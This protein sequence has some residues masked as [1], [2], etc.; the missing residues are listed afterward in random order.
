MHGVVT[1]RWLDVE[2]EERLQ[3]KRELCREKRPG[4]HASWGKIGGKRRPLGAKWKC[5]TGWKRYKKENS[6]LGRVCTYSI[7]NNDNHN[8][9]NVC[10]QRVTWVFRKISLTK[11]W[12]DVPPVISPKVSPLARPPPSDPH[13]RLPRLTRY[14]AVRLTRI[15]GSYAAGVRILRFIVKSGFCVKAL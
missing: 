4:D 2:G 11:S 8:N 12:E 7:N 13:H 14:S 15:P 5:D 3:R 1:R 6:K 9:N 10:A